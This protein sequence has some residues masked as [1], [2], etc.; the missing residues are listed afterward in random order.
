MVEH[1]GHGAAQRLGA[2]EHDQQ[3]A[4]DVQPAV[5]QPNQHLGD[6]GGVR[7]GA[8]GQSEG[9][10]VPSRVIPRATTQQCSATRIPSP[11]AP[12][13]PASTAQRP[14]ARPGRARSG[15]RT[16]ATPPTWRSPS[17]PGRPGCRPVPAR[18]GRGGST[19]WPASAPPPA[20]PA[21]RWRRTPDRS[22]P[23]AHR[24]RRR[25]GLAVGAPAPGGRPRSP[26]PARCHDGP[27]SAP[28]CGGPW[29]PPA[30]RRPRPSWPAAP[31]GRAPP[32]RP[33]V[34]HGRRR[35]VRPRPRSPARAGDPRPGRW[36][37]CAGYP[38]ARR[39]PSGRASWPM[40]D[41][42]HPAGIRRGPPPQP[43]RDPRQPLA[44]P[45]ACATARRSTR[46]SRTI[47]MQAG[48]LFAAGHSQAQVARQ[49]GC[50]PCR[51]RP[52]PP[53]GCPRPRLRHRQLG[54][55]PHHQ[56]G[57][58]S[59]TRE[60]RTTRSRDGATA[61]DGSRSDRCVVE[62]AGLSLGDAR[63]GQP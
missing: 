14:A 60:L 48:A 19:A 24:C 30:G 38:S 35:P 22:A 61:Q 56:R 7:G 29:R 55:C 37:Q 11:A 45:A 34:P 63:Q 58:A 9:T 8:L 52:G 51:H 12:P 36:W 10:L 25:S 6:Q 27:R 5:A 18:P 54:A 43:L 32:P 3:R 46:R 31:A 57:R 39:S 53:P 42:Y 4:G 2:V 59:F 15:P 28:G 49:L 50:Q 1:L 62:F 13:A 26:G 17:W 20:A 40:P 16:D 21:G 47:R 23:A 44:T 41:T 33:T